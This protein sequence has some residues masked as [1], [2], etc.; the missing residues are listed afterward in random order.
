MATAAGYCPQRAASPTAGFRDTAM[1]QDYSTLPADS[2]A[3]A[4]YHPPAA[5]PL[6]VDFDNRIL[7][8]ALPR[9]LW[10]DTIAARD[11]IPLSGVA[12]VECPVFQQLG[13]YDPVIP[14]SL[15]E[16]ERECWKRSTEVVVE[17]VAYVGHGFNLHLNHEQGWRAIDRYFGGGW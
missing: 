1:Q 12:D 7:R 10:A 14:G 17:Q 11:D 8:T 15:A 3:S 6:V 16:L 2:R 5:D 4:F 13:A 9:R